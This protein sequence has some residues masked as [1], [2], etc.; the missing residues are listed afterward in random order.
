MRILVANIVVVNI[1]SVFGVRTMLGP[2]QHRGRYSVPS[3]TARDPKCIHAQVV[4]Q[5][6]EKNT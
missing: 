1:E 4:P 3:D 6:I 5:V 2:V